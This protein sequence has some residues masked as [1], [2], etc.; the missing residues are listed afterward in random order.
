[1]KLI[2]FVIAAFAFSGMAAAQDGQVDSDNTSQSGRIWSEL[3]QSG[4]KRISFD[5]A[6]IER[7]KGKFR[8]TGRTL[9]PRPDE[10]GVIELQHLGEIRC[11][12]KSFRIISFKALAPDGRVVTSYTPPKS[13]KPEP[14]GANTPNDKLHSEFCS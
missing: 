11:S 9:F 14:I 6:S 7:G 8:Y 13:A 1:M 4:D 5:Q 3:Q 2:G 10:N 12:P